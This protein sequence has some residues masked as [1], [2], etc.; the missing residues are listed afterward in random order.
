[1]QN[2]FDKT[3]KSDEQILKKWQDRRGASTRTN[4]I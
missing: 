3:G 2:P 4:L 1:M